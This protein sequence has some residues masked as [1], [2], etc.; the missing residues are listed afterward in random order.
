MGVI[1]A[2]TIAKTATGTP[3]SVN[4]DSLARGLAGTVAVLACDTSIPYAQA[5]RLRS[6]YTRV[7]RGMPSELAALAL[8]PPHCRSAS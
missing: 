2:T 4:S 1:S 3:N 6:L 8:L 5:S 7:V